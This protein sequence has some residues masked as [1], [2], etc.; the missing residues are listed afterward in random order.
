MM[1]LGL[2]FV[3]A[4][5]GVAAYGLG[6]IPRRRELPV[7]SADTRSALEILKARLA[8]GEIS[9]E[10]YQKLRDKLA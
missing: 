7:P 5:I 9:V 4:V 1:G 6:W 3:V 8:S 10:E 2:L